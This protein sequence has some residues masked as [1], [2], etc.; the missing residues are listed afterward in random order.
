MT[1]TISFDEL[2]EKYTENDPTPLQKVA[3]QEAPDLEQLWASALNN[4][5]ASQEEPSMNNMELG[6]LYKAA[7]DYVAYQS[8]VDQMNKEAAAEQDFDYN[9]EVLYKQAQMG[10]QTA[11][12]EFQKMAAAKEQYQ[13]DLLGYIFAHGVREGIKIAQAEGVNIPLTPEDGGS[14]APTAVPNDGTRGIGPAPAMGVS[15]NANPLNT[16]NLGDK[17]LKQIAD[18]V[19]NG[20][21]GQIIPTGN[22]VQYAQQ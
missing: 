11:T 14:L 19:I 10:N 20:L 6:I 22:A 8:Q 18:G 12:F 3:S 7:G 15:V 16:A 4:K 17:S 5:T 13:E 2:F 9:M 1:Q 21:S